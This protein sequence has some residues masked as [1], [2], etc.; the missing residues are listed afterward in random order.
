MRTELA[1][2][3]AA[4]PRRPAAEARVIPAP[5]PAAAAQALVELGRALVEHDYEFVTVTPATHARMLQRRGEHATDLRD[6]F[7]WSRPFDADLLPRAM[8]E[9]LRASGCCAAE[10]TRLRSTIRFASFESHLFAH[11]AY[12]TLE[13]DAVFFGPDS[14]RFAAAVMRHAPHSQRIVDVGCGT[15]VGGIVVA[16]RGRQLVLADVS[17]RALFFAHVNAQ[18]AGIAPELVHSDVL[19][20][21]DGDIDLVIANPPYLLDDAG[22][23]Y[24]DGGGELG[25]GLAVR[26]VDQALQRLSPGG[27]LIV[28]T[29][30]PIVDGCDIFLRAVSPILARSHATACY[31]EL[32]PDVFGEELERPEYSDVERI[33]AVLLRVTVDG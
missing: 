18:L 19:D 10:G 2:P 4:C 22:R 9:L 21:V 30:T 13:Q 14:Y 6:V 24:R 33:A 23:T 16:S 31:E 29:G 28:Y 25:E 3:A 11:S 7:G 27:S 20:A 26:I 12:P 1:G 17:E 5:A 8:L 32:D 15:G